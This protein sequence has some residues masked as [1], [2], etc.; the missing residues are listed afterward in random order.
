ML[1]VPAAPSIPTANEDPK[2]P[3]GTVTK[4]EAVTEPSSRSPLEEIHP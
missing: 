4:A 2:D 1:T 3:T